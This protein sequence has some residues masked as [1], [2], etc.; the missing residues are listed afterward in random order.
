MSLFFTNF[1]KLDLDLD[2]DPHSEN[3]WIRIRKNEC[4]GFRQD[5]YFFIGTFPLSLYTG[6]TLTQI[7]EVPVA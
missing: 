5:M 7:Y 4:N 3:C 2:Q 1:V 6:L